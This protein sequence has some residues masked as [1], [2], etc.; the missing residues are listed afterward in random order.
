MEDHGLHSICTMALAT[1]SQVELFTLKPVWPIGLTHFLTSFHSLTHTEPK[2]SLHIACCVHSPS[3]RRC[4]HQAPAPYPLLDPLPFQVLTTVLKRSV[5]VL[6]YDW[7]LI[8]PKIARL[9]SHFVL[10]CCSIH[11]HAYFR[12]THTHTYTYSFMHS[13]G[14][15][16]NQNKKKTHIFLVF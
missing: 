12:I 9:R 15:I 5:L 1:A 4:F 3:I 2:L 6:D 14:P 7:L 11:T 13:H 10:Y 8:F 16:V